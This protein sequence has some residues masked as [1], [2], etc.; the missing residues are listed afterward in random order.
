LGA[1]FVAEQASL[2]ISSPAISAKRAI[3]PDN[4]MAWDENGNG[5]GG[6]SLCDRPSGEGMGFGL[7]HDQAPFEEPPPC[8]RS[9][10]LASRALRSK[11]KTRLN[12]PAG[13]LL[14]G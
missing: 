14:Q 11:E 7:R 6:A 13:P 10:R 5:I 8:S 12:A 3:G 9:F 2:A 1:A 4:A